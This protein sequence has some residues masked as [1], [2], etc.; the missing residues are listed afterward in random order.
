MRCLPDA[1]QRRSCSVPVTNTNDAGDGCY[2]RLVVRRRIRQRVGY[3]LILVVRA[4]LANDYFTDERR[5]PILQNGEN[6]IGTTATGFVD[7]DIEP[8]AS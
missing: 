3:R 6:I 4:G 7:A 8:T 2:V 5:C 1:S